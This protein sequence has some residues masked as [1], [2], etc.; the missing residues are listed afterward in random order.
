MTPSVGERR[1]YNS[2]ALPLLY[3]GECA[4][5]TGVTPIDTNTYT[6]TGWLV[7]PAPGWRACYHRWCYRLIG[8]WFKQGQPQLTIRA[9]VQSNYQQKD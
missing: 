6:V 3:P 4:I 9:E 5:P 1:I 7:E 2:N 8:H